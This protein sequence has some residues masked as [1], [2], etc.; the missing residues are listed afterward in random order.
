M[1]NYYDDNIP[2]DSP[3]VTIELAGVDIY[4]TYKSIAF[5]LEKWS[6]GEPEEQERLFMLKDFFY[7]MVLEYKYN[8]ED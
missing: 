6:G 3:Y 7:R 8:L 2:D 1:H 4:L 5:H